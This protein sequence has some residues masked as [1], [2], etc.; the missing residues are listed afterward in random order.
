METLSGSYQDYR[1]RASNLLLLRGVEHSLRG[2]IGFDFMADQ[3]KVAR[4]RDNVKF[5]NLDHC[6][7]AGFTVQ[8]GGLPEVYFLFAWVRNNV[9][10]CSDV[11]GNCG[12][13][14]S[15]FDLGYKVDGAPLS[16]RWSSI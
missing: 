2:P 14:N 15:P 1:F 11:R 4:T 12:P 9:E 13:I 6:F 5:Y 16:H 10:V 7:A 8:A 3:D